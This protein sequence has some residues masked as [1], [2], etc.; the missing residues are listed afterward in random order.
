MFPGLIYCPTD[1]SVVLLVFFSGKVFITGAKTMQDVY[2][3]WK[4]FIVI[5]QAY[6]PDSGATPITV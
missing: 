2:D 1:M 3:S 4:L 6:K 5:L